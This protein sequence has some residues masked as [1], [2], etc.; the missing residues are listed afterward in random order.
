VEFQF[1]IAIF[2]DQINLLCLKSRKLRIS[3]SRPHQIPSWAINAHESSIDHNWCLRIMCVNLGTKS[4]MIHKLEKSCHQIKIL[5]KI[6]LTE[7]T[8]NGQSLSRCPIL[9]FCCRI[10]PTN[11]RDCY[12]DRDQNAT[13]Y[14]LIFY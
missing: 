2:Y 13:G 4:K 7:L 3:P 9:G 10:L 1:P 8:L 12:L 6:E 14:S 5:H 11:A